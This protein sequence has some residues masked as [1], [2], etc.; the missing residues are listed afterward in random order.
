[1]T[2]LG[3]EEVES[4]DP[5]PYWD[6]GAGI[7]WIPVFGLQPDTELDEEHLAKVLADAVMQAL[8]ILD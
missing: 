1:M 3:S 6:P 5:E 7:L 4:T 8:G 2:D